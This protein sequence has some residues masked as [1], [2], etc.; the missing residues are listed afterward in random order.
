MVV[1][2]FLSVSY[3]CSLICPSTYKT[4]TESSLCIKNCAKLLEL[5]GETK[6]HDAAIKEGYTCQWD[7]I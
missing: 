5:N 4:F 6:R 1:G 7:D 3:G 2:N